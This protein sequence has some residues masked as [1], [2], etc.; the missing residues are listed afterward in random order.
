M[1]LMYTVAIFCIYLVYAPWNETSL[2]L[3]LFL[4]RIYKSQN[5]ENKSQIIRI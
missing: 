1:L 5:V 3:S 2:A 4:K